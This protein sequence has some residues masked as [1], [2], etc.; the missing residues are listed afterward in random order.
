MFFF[1]IEIEFDDGFYGANTIILNNG[2]V[3]VDTN[4]IDDEVNFNKNPLEELETE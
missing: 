1:F 2:T 3:D 4:I